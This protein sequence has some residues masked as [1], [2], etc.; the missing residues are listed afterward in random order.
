M[1]RTTRACPRSPPTRPKQA[2]P[3][4]NPRCAPSTYHRL[5]RLCLAPSLGNEKAG[6]EQLNVAKRLAQPPT[7][8]ALAFERLKRGDLQ[9]GGTSRDTHGCGGVAV[10]DR[11]EPG[12]KA[13]KGARESGSRWGASRK[14][15]CRCWRMRRLRY[16]SSWAP[17][18]SRPMARVCAALRPFRL[19][20]RALSSLNGRETH[21]NDIARPVRSFVRAFDRSLHGITRHV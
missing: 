1:P 16:E 14:E 13:E 6:A 12:A 7:N 18:F 4:L 9:E 8:P 19:R 2:P 15:P 20:A 17:R 21:P 10:L 11:V 3:A 5:A